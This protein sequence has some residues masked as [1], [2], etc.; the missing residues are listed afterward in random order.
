MNICTD[1]EAAFRLFDENWYS[2][3]EN[4]SKVSRPHQKAISF[5]RNNLGVEG[6]KPSYEWVKKMLTTYAPEH[7]E[8]S[9]TVMSDYPEK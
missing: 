7:F 3:K 4:K 2:I 6:R 9:E 1:H 5:A 8:F